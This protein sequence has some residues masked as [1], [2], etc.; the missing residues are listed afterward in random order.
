MTLSVRVKGALNASG[1]LRKLN[2]K[3]VSIVSA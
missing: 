1:N 3:F 2:P